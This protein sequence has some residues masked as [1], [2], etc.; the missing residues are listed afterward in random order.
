MII[1]NRLYSKIPAIA[2]LALLAV[3]I[4]PALASSSAIAADW[5]LVRISGD[6]RVHSTDRGWRK[7]VPDQAL[8][9]GDSVWTGRGARA[10]VAT[11]DGAVLLKARSLVK[12]PAQKLPDGM[13]VLFQGRG[14]LKATVRKKKDKHFSVQTPFLAAV[15]KGTEFS[16]DIGKRS[17]RLSVTEGVVGAVG[18]GG[19]KVV[20]VRAGQSLTAANRPVAS[21][22]AANVSN[23]FSGNGAGSSTGGSSPAG[24]DDPDNRSGGIF[25]GERIG[26]GGGSGDPDDP[27]DPDDD[28]PGGGSGGGHGHGHGYGPG[29][30]HGYG[31]GRGRGHG[32]GHGGF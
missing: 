22:S 6:V 2:G 4:L 14:K 18:A 16:V 30:G 1:F 17:T 21:I 10:L 12:V 27:G 7:A 31:Y 25:G 9:P 15:V 3:S 19:G 28:D 32:Y 20:D 24:K 29:H 23:D 13:T 5:R 26:K 11:D 8:Q